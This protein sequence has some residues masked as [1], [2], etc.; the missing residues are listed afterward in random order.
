MA[1]S[2]ASWRVPLRLRGRYGVVVAP[3]AGCMPRASSVPTCRSPAASNPVLRL[4]RHATPNDAGVRRPSRRGEL[5][6]HTHRDGI[7]ESASRERR[8]KRNSRV[9]AA[10]S[11][12]DRIDCA[13][14]HHDTPDRVSSGASSQANRISA[15]TH[16]VKLSALHLPPPQWGN[17]LKGFWSHFKNSVRGTHK[18][19]SRRHMQYLCEFEFRFNHRRST[20]SEMFDQLIQAF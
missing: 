18:S 16:S 14:I 17:T 3:D 15:S 2:N 1:S 11:V 8:G 5:S 19:L 20:S 9:A 12:L 13:F 6:F 10:P 4:T 7:A